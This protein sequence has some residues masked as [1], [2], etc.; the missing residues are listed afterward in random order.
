MTNTEM[1]LK[2]CCNHPYLIEGVEDLELKDKELNEDE[3]INMMVKASSKLT[4]IDGILP[5]IKQKGSKVVIYFQLVRMMDIVEDYLRHRGFSFERID[6]QVPSVERQARLSRF[7]T[8]SPDPF[9]FLATTRSST[10]PLDL[11]AA[12]TV[13]FF[14][15]DPNPE[16]DEMAL[17]S[18]YGVGQNRPVSVMRL[19][20]R[21]SYESSLYERSHPVP[22]PPVVPQA[23]L[24]DEISSLLKFGSAAVFAQPDNSINTEDP[25]FW[26]KVLLDHH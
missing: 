21:L 12:D 11:K 24:G 1:L 20:T 25:N 10:K 9:I 16:K 5:E 18:V 17:K 8:P 4:F 3:I 2:K 19:L 22:S 14:D 23:A 7:S 13:I 26:K 15:N 6:G